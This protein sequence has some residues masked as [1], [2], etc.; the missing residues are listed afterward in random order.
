MALWLPQPLRIIW[1]I[2]DIILVLLPSIRVKCK[3]SKMA[4][5]PAI[6]HLSNV[7]AKLA[8]WPRVDL[9][10]IYW[11]GSGER[12][13]DVHSQT[14]IFEYTIQIMW[15]V[16]VFVFFFVPLLCFF[17]S[18]ALFKFPW[19]CHL[20]CLCLVVLFCLSKWPRFRFPR[21]LQILTSCHQN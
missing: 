11:K 17:F 2:I 1:I 5:S 16:F 9:L 14:L 19:T 7:L 4:I 10:P 6:S 20:L 3:K 15:C 8:E 21:T 13:K 18:R 12:G